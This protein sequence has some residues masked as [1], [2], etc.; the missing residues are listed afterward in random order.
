MTIG[1]T[2]VRRLSPSSYGATYISFST[3]IADFLIK[4]TVLGQ[5]TKK[6]AEVAAEAL[7]QK[8]RVNYFD[9]APENVVTILENP[10]NSYSAVKVMIA[11]KSYQLLHGFSTKEECY[12]VA[13]LY[14]KKHEV[15]LLFRANPAAKKIKL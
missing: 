14:A 13:N 4:E 9:Y 7:A 5:M 2:T 1:Y 11:E 12:R 10:D 8:N 3:K 6:S 15:Q